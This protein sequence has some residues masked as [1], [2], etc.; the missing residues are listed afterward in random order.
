[1]SAPGQKTVRPWWKRLLGWVHVLF[2]L[3]LLAALILQGVLLYLLW[4]D[5][6]LPIPDFAVQKLERAVAEQGLEID[7][8]RM[9]FDLRGILLLEDI[10]VSLPGY[11]EPVAEIDLIM[12]DFPPWA[13]LDRK[14]LPNEVWLSR[15]NLYCPSVL[16]PT[17]TRERVAE[18]IFTEVAIR[19]QRL[20]LDR[21]ILKVDGLDIRAEGSLPV[22]MIQKLTEGPAMDEKERERLMAEGYTA[23]C[24]ALLEAR[25]WVERFTDPRIQLQLGVSGE[26][27]SV[28]AQFQAESF[29]L[30]QG[31]EG[32][33][34]VA[35]AQAVGA[36]ADS[37]R[38]KKARARV[39]QLHWEDKVSARFAAVEAVIPN[40][41][42]QALP[43]AC[44]YGAAGVEGMNLSA[45][46]VI[47]QVNFAQIKK[48][49][50]WIHI[51]SGAN[52]LLVEGRVDT[53]QE[54]ANLS[55]DAWWDPLD[56]LKISFL[57]GKFT[58]PPDLDCSERPR[59]G[60]SVVLDKGYEFDSAEVYLDF[61]KTRY[62][63]LNLLSA[64]AKAR[65]TPT[66]VYVSQAE[67]TTARYTVNGT[68]REE[69]DTKRYRYLLN[70]NVDP[71]EIS[72]LIDADWWDP[73]WKDFDF[74][75]VMPYSN[76][77]IQGTYGQGD[78]GKTFFGYN[79]LLDFS[80][81]GVE[82]NAFTAMLW[83]EQARIIL[84]DMDGQSNSGD[85][86][87]AIQFSYTP[88]GETRTSL[89][90]AA[91]TTLPLKEAA[92]LAGDEALS[93]VE[94]FKLS[95]APRLQ[96]NGLTVD[97]VGGKD[98]ELFLKIIADMDDRVVYE[99]FIFDH[100]AFHGMKQPDVL[101]LRKIAFG[102]AGG[103]GT[104]QADVKLVDGGEGNEMALG[105]SLRGASYAD[106]LTSVPMLSTHSET[107]KNSKTA[108]PPTTSSE[109]KAMEL[110]KIDFDLNAQGTTGDVKT[111]RGHGQIG[112]SNALLGQ[113]H[114]FGGLSR[115]IQ[116]IGL[117][118][119]TVDFTKGTAPFVLGKGYAHFPGL[120]ISG[121]TARIDA[122]GNFNL[123]TG[124]LDFYLSLY[125]LG[126]VDIPLISTIFSAINPLTDVVEAQLTGTASEPKWAVDFRPLGIITGQKQ[127]DNPTGETLPNKG[128][129]GQYIMDD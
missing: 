28:I 66:L 117:N 95:A 34:I 65:I 113:F 69:L 67:L 39:Q 80:Y 83:R 120:T 59:W 41:G 32:E 57:E 96:V 109:K 62:E 47:G 9:K 52:W 108:Q 81:Q 93:Y 123:D 102:M 58:H 119:G 94:D 36:G 40:K 101:Q 54:T 70:G 7:I 73:L 2:N 46:V 127:V 125:P 79:E 71:L 90:F 115:A 88:D 14:L 110:A 61:G 1:M 105:L 76:I 64:F 128:Q 74:H 68:Y 13:L 118:L 10:K 3:G 30:G 53:E 99:G 98:D 91:A 19:H 86:N 15:C 51:D 18:D 5:G 23:F 12:V 92:S 11:H 8:A 100:L 106:L 112:I 111:F 97:G 116:A 85:F 75:G 4:E 38:L 45:E 22:T 25:P 56:L 17:G 20:D 33:R 31:V 6:E 21:L 87:A 60:G 37:F 26:Q 29:N 89:G 114:I 42:I 44:H 55:V 48:P 63:A 77:D 16:S 124:E 122:N 50:G 78:L 84:Y 129:S 43:T 24:R 49:S 121:P 103:E 72:F 82:V 104:G 126:G 35:T 27:A 107:V